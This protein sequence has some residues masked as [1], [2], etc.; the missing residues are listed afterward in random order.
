MRA[1][2]TR[3]YIFRSLPGFTPQRWEK[4]ADDP[5]YCSL[6]HLSLVQLS[7]C[8]LYSADQRRARGAGSWKQLGR[9]RCERCA[10]ENHET[11][12][13]KRTWCEVWFERLGMWPDV[14]KK[15]HENLI[16]FH[17]HISFMSSSVKSHLE[18]TIKGNISVRTAP[19]PARTEDRGELEVTDCAQALGQARALGRILN[20]AACKFD[21]NDHK[22][23]F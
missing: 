14:A 22:N 4:S 10:E 20:S 5:P 21:T 12:I 19:K 3:I 17:L 9:P 7:C 23:H 18:R 13:S 1:F 8:L 2:W 15:Q 16:Y 11:D 6:V